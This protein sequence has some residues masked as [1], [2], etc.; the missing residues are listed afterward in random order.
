[1]YYQLAQVREFHTHFRQPVRRNPTLVEV[2]PA[3]RGLRYRLIQEEVDELQDALRHGDV[4]KTLDALVDLLYVTYGAAHA[5]GMADVLPAAFDE[6]HRSNM[7]K[8]GD[9]ATLE[10]VEASGG[11][12]PLGKVM[13]GDG[14]S[15]P[16]LK[17]FLGGIDATLPGV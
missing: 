9:K 5:F 13:K 8:T 11:K 3:E 16:N 4:E 17:Q 15:P 1:M 7:T 6:V 10:Q 2:S 14:Y 12:V